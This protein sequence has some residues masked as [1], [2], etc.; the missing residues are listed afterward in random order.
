MSEYFAYHFYIKSRAD[1][2]GRE[3][4]AETMKMQ[5]IETALFGNSLECVL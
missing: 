5:I 1:A 2:F 4:M 3:G